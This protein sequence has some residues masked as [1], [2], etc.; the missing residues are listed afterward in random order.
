MN[1]FRQASVQSVDLHRYMEQP[2]LGPAQLP[3]RVGSQQIGATSERVGQVEGA[4]KAVGTPLDLPAQHRL[5][6]VRIEQL[7]IEEAAGIRRRLGIRHVARQPDRLAHGIA[8]P[9]EVNIDF[10]RHGCLLR[11]Q[12]SGQQQAEEG[13]DEVAHICKVTKNTVILPLQCTH[14]SVNNLRKLLPS[15]EQGRS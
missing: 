9:V 14:L 5:T 11:R 13:K 3:A 8:G 6:L 15:A 7:H 10:L 4:R 2:V 12:D 1:G